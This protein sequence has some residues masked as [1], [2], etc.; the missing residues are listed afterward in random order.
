MDGNANECR[1]IWNNRGIKEALPSEGGLGN[2]SL[3]CHG[4]GLSHFCGVEKSSE[5]NFS[6]EV[7]KCTNRY[8]LSLSPV[9]AALTADQKRKHLKKKAEKKTKVE[10]DFLLW[11]SSEICSSILFMFLH[12]D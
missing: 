5:A 4:N 9:M 10:K 8:C 11:E 3:C 7:V 1:D 6:T 12:A 2:G